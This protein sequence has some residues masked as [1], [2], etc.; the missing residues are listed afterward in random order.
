MFLLWGNV[1]SAK[2]KDSMITRDSMTLGG[3]GVPIS[4]AKI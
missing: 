1:L 4:L 3:K 2:V